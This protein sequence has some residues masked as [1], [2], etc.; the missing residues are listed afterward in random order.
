MAGIKKI[1]IVSS[2]HE[3]SSSSESIYI[4]FHNFIYFGHMNKPPNK[5]NHLNYVHVIYLIFS[6]LKFQLLKPIHNSI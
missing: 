1:C 5:N 3:S 6:A 2:F 4:L